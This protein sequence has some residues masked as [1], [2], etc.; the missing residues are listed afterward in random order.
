MCPSNFAFV[1]S[2]NEC[3]YNFVTDHANARALPTRG[4]LLEILRT[5]NSF[6]PTL[7]F[8]LAPS[9]KQ[10]TRDIDTS[11][12]YLKCRSSTRM[13]VSKLPARYRGKT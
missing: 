12:T 13:A 4:F 2:D 11:D 10:Q 8:N 6:D 7:I 5:L 9:N 3:P 1:P